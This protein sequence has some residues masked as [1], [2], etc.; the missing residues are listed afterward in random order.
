M[1]KAKL[2]PALPYVG[3]PIIGA[4]LLILRAGQLDPFMVLRYE[5]LI[6]IGYVAAIGDMKAKKI[7][8]GLI[9]AMMASWVLIMTP[10]LFF[11]TDAAIAFLL[12]SAVGFATGGGMLLLG[13]LVR[14]KGLGGG[15]VK[16]M[17]ASGLYLG[18]GGVLSAM[19]C[20]TVL[21][22]LTGIAL[23]LLKRIG[24]KDTIPL[25]PFLYAGFIVTVFLH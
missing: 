6:I 22:S 16:F 14:R 23:I 3:I 11:D 21:A 12:D 13:Y 7:P 24:R 2:F 25:A 18:A 20:G 17:A 10:I 8:N 9:L 5:V 15:D 1:T 19:F 4:A